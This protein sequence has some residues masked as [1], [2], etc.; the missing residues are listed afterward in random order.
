MCLTNDS[1]LQSIDQGPHVYSSKTDCTLRQGRCRHGFREEA[2]REDPF[3]PSESK[4]PR[5]SH[6]A[7]DVIVQEGWLQ[8]D[9]AD[10]PA[11]SQGFAQP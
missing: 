10:T 6:L 4:E 9:V 2:A 3:F 7:V 1:T 11:S 8:S 5:G